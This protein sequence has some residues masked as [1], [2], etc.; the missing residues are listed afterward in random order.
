LLPCHYFLPFCLFTLLIVSFVVQKLLSLIRSRLF[1][2]ACISVPGQV[3]ATLAAPPRTSYPF[4]RHTAIAS[5][6][7]LRESY[8]FHLTGFLSVALG[9]TWSS[10]LRHKSTLGRNRAFREK[11]LC[12]TEAFN[13]C[14]FHKIPWSGKNPPY[15]H[16]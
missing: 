3:T 4:L 9:P 2:F 15:S 6:L 12:E 1:I 13:L 7:S 14:S 5:V 8:P 11:P 16:T 10:P